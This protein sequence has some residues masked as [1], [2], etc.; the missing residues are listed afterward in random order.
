[1][2]G[3]SYEAAPMHFL[4]DAVVFLVAAV[5]GVGLFK[6]L[7][8][9]AVLGYLAAGVA[10]GPS[11]LKLVADV[12][13][14]MSIS[15]L[16]VVMLLFVIG[17]ELQPRR[18]W[19][20]RAHVFGLGS[21]QVFG[22]TAVFLG[23]GFLIGLPPVTAF[24]LAFA[25]SL[26]STALAVQALAERNQLATQHGRVAFGILLFQDVVAIP[27]LA[28]VPALAGTGASATWFGV[29]KVVLTL[30][31]MVVVS[32]FVLRPALKALASLRVPE[33]FTA[34]ALL[35]VVGTALLME[36]I[37]LSA[38]LGAF[39][40]G[41]LLADSEYRHELEADL[42]P[43]K[44]LLLGLFFIA[45][46][47]SV[48]LSLAAERPLVVTGIVLG[49]V[50]VKGLVLFAMGLW[51]L[52]DKL[53][54]LRLAVSTSQGGEFA[55]VVVSLATSTSLVW[56]ELS[57]LVVFV[58]GA[59]LATTPIFFALFERFVAPRLERK[60]ERSFDRVE[61]PSDEPPVI[62]AG[63]GRV[64]QVV[65]RV[66]SAR[67][68]PFVALD[69]SPDHVDFIR[70]FGNKVFYGDAS[71][72]E[73]LEAAGAAKA[74]VFVLAIDDPKASV[75]TAAAVQKHYPH[76]VIFARA[77]NRQHAYELKAMGVHQ[78][79]RET[80]ATSLELTQAVLQQLGLPFSEALRTIEVFRDHDERLLEQSFHLRG[81][82]ASLQQ[83]A[84]DARAELEKLFDADATSMQ[85]GG[86]PR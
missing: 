79:H 34:S 19:Q 76:L 78:L 17:L 57:Q 14:V 75:A 18:L 36:L 27:F 29:A 54:A 72:L 45:V 30:G 24:V 46:G 62:I 55:F 4:H 83:V 59:S 58:V 10:I 86:G 25:L 64:G 44:G 77:R 56:P 5:I 47:M 37:G 84:K 41:V 15:E 60:K 82:Y 16:G 33:L 51:R 71:R 53:A 49:L 28:L 13:R 35:V 42:A 8:L 22:T 48:N 40:A 3:L 2:R 7:G 80:L 43:F 21:I 26:S 20:L 52:K 38:T 32:R 81:D 69:A 61:L 67:R 73:L 31:G 9:G 12:Q 70:R 66:L 85:D 65:G 11:G 74:R 1:M 23:I 50:A 68:I 63:F 6:R 39:L